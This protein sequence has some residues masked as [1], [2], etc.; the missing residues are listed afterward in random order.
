MNVVVWGVWSGE[1]SDRTLHALFPTKDLAE[2]YAADFGIGVPGYG[3]EIEPHDVLTDVAQWAEDLLRKHEADANYESWQE[4]RREAAREAARLRREAEDA[5]A[6]AEHLKAQK[7][8]AVVGQPHR[9]T[10]EQ[11]DAESP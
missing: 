5:R 8:A 6:Y 9:L 2:R 11:I 4:E 1:Y 3:P 10:R 7:I